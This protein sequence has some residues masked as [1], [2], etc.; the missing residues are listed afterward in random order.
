MY[1]ED[2]RWE[3]V[4]VL[5]YRLMALSVQIKGK[6]TIRC[7]G[8]FL[9]ICEDFSRESKFMGHRMLGRS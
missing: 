1:R 3:L 7:S 6:V 4:T 5:V 8:S 2:P 9:I